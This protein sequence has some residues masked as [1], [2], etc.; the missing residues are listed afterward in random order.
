M[1]YFSTSLPV[2]YQPRNQ[3]DCRLQFSGFYYN[4]SLLIY[5]NFIGE[6][7][8]RFVASQYP[9]IIR[10]RE[11]YGTPHS[12]HQTID[13]ENRAACFAFTQNVWFNCRAIRSWR[14]DLKIGLIEPIWN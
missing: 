9:I 2:S 4:Q 12:S 5:Y 11:K 14:I 3:P 13:S 8:L 7:T 6:D 1:L 10:N